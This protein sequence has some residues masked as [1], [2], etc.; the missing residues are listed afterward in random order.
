MIGKPGV[1]PTTYLGPPRCARR[2]LA[3]NGAEQASP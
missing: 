2:L 1:V 3:L